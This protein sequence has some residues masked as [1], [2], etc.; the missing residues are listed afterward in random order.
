MLPEDLNHMFHVHLRFAYSSTANLH[1][2]VWAINADI[3]WPFAI[4]AQGVHEANS[5]LKIC[6]VR[7]TADSRTSAICTTMYEMRMCGPLLSATVIL[8]PSQSAH[9]L[10]SID[11]YRARHLCPFILRQSEHLP[12][13][14]H[15]TR[16]IRDHYGRCWYE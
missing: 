12:D 14:N 4:A 3:C 2:K 15:M 8:K 16:R 6:M 11:A 7:R 13:C 5:L 10:H 9:G 1:A